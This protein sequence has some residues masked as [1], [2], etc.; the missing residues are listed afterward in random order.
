MDRLYR[1]RPS[2]ALAFIRFLE[3]ATL[4][5]RTASVERQ[6]KNGIEKSNF[7]DACAR[8]RDGVYA[9]VCSMVSAARRQAKRGPPVSAVPAKPIAVEAGECGL[10]S[11]W[12]DR[13][14]RGLHREA[15]LESE[16]LPALSSH[17]CSLRTF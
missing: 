11:F 3:P 17:E 14:R 9:G 15:T 12:V 8:A 1:H 5:S 10:A 7:P 13:V 6:R 2:P 16:Y 4:K